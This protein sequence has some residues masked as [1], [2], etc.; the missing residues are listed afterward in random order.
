MAKPEELEM[1]RQSMVEELQAI[2]N[3]QSRISAAADMELKR[4]LQHNM[5]EEKEHTA[6]LMEWL[7]NNDPVQNKVFEKHD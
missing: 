1:A 7:R 3:Y 4:I 5:D 2:N 6:M